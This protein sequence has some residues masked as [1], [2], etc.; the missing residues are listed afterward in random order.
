MPWRFEATSLTGEPFGEIDN[1][2]GRTVTIPLSRQ[3]TCSF[4]LSLRH[5]LAD[6]LL[7]S[8][9]LIKCYDDNTLRFHGLVSSA[10]EVAKEGGGGTVQFT[11]T[12]PFFRLFKRRIGKTMPGYT[13]GTALAPVERGLI[14]KGIIDATNAEKETGIRTVAPVTPSSSTFV[15]PWPYKQAAEAIQE[16]AATLDGY[17]WDLFPIEYSAGKIAEFR[18]YGAIGTTQVNAAFEYGHGKH[19]VKSYKRPVSLEGM[20]NQGISLPPGFPDQS[21]QQVLTWKD[22]AAINRWGLYEDLVDSNL[23]VDDL[24]LK[25]LQEHVRVRKNPRQIWSFEPILDFST[26]KVPNFGIDYTVGDIVPF[27]V[28]VNINGQE[29]T[30]ADVFVRVFSASFSIDDNGVVTSTTV[31]ANED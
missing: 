30:R 8:D 16:L 28:K 23:I 25:L 22:Q 29:V 7:S 4:Q 27:R 5:R 24:R 20:L 10:E 31:I 21:T 18:T 14:A 12:D 19:N 6:R 2:T 15:G 26:G 11:C 9:A 13:Q 3:R 1:A 17:E